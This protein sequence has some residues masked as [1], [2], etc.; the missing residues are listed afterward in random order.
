MPAIETQADADE[1][2]VDLP[3][4]GESVDVEVDSSE[5]RINKEDDVEI[6]S[7]VIVDNFIR[8]FVY[9]YINRISC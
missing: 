5:K 9:L 7:E 2:M 4:T 6:I 1:K 8:T 3:S